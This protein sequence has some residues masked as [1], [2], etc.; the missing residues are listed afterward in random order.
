[1]LVYP[2]WYGTFLMKKRLLL[3]SVLGGLA[4]ACIPLAAHASASAPASSRSACI[5]AHVNGIPVQIGYA[6]DGPGG[7]T[8]LN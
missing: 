5:V 8:Q 6:P 2:N 1:M 3:A 4:A 7:C